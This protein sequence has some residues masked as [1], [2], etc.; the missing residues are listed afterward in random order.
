MMVVR[1]EDFPGCDVG[2]RNVRILNA[3]PGTDAV[4]RHR[5]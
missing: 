1:G 4:F 5:R 2:F 3:A